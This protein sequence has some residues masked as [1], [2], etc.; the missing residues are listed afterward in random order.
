MLTYYTIF[1]IYD[2]PK[3]HLKNQVHLQSYHFKLLI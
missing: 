1:K 3:P 2:D